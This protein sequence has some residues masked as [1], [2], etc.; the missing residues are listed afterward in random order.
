[1]LKD[2]RLAVAIVLVVLTLAAYWRAIDC[3]FLTI[4]DPIYV[5]KNPHVQEGLTARSISWAFT[6]TRS[7]NWH[8]LTWLSHQTDYA[9]FGRRAWGHHLTALLLHAANV[10]LL[11]LVLSSMTGSMWRSAFV[12]AL[13]ALHPL[14]VESVAWVAERKDVLSA[15]FW[16]L[17]MLAYASYIRAPRV[18]PYLLMVAAFTLGLMAKPMLVTLP[19]VLLFLDLWPLSGSRGAGPRHPT[20]NTQHPFLEKTP[21]FALAFASCVVTYVVQQTGGAVRTAEQ[22]PILV[23]VGNAIV[24]YVA[25][26]GKMLWPARLSIFYPHPGALPAWLVISCAVLLAGATY[27]AVR[28]ARTRPYLTVGWLWYVVTLIPVIGLVQVG[29]Q[30]MADRYTY[31]PLIGLFIIVAWGVPDLFARVIGSVR[32]RNVALAAA[33]AVVVIACA[34]ATWVEVGYWRDPVTIFEHALRSTR[35]HY[36]VH[37]LLAD[38]LSDTGKPDEAVSHLEQAIKANP[39]FAPAY[40]NLGM[41]RLQQGRPDQAI[42]YYE[43]A[44]R[45]DPKLG[46]AHND[47]G[48]VL[49]QQGR[50]SEAVSHF[51]R[52]IELDPRSAQARYNLGVACDK[53]GNLPE[54]ASHYEEAAR[55]D[56]D[57]PDAH[58]SLA[59][60]LTRQQR[61]SEAA[62]ELEEALRL[63][64]DMVEA[65]FYMGYILAL[66][67]EP[68][69]AISHFRTAIRI[70]PTW[71]MPHFGLADASARKGDYASAWKELHRSI[72]L[73]YKPNPAFVGAL[74]RRMPDPDK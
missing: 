2:G 58:F 49:L 60:A 21:L 55:L 72:E 11:F 45:I 37:Y 54:A 42:D 40:V 47:L 65:H 32:V 10:L 74:S 46:P 15:F 19:L 67:G 56:P 50:T 16:M 52:A 20:P 70:K 8:P 9:L 39:E 35:G 59:T 18:V 17:T 5:T 51:Q 29:R 34:K 53:L 68:D 23:R 24:S 61:L 22:Y 62:R 57:F 6:T 30:A 1:M 64:P 14:H 69:E 66:T 13:F 4:D 27:G 38:A 48:F 3:K 73:G 33:G 63:K 36:A 25:Y 7:A 31:V 44:L 28:A 71:A 43:H 12:A 26:I 41:I